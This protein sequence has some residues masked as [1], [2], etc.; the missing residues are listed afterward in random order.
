MGW[1]SDR[2]STGILKQGGS[3]AG[4]CQASSV[5][6]GRTRGVWRACFPPR[7]EP[8]PVKTTPILGCLELEL[9]RQMLAWRLSE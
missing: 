7:G 9:T 2:L 8:V 3:R 5:F 4:C 1:A 6:G